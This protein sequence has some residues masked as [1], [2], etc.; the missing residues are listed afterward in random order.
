MR[1]ISSRSLL[2]VFIALAFCTDLAQAQPALNFKRIVNNW[3][4]IELYMNPTCNGKKIWFTDKRFF[5]IR[6]NGRDIGDFELWC[7]DPTVRCAVSIALALDAGA[8]MRGPALDS[9]RR[10]CKAFVALFDGVNDEAAITTFRDVPRLAVPMT[11]DTARMQRGIDSIRGEGP[12]A[13]WDGAYAALLDLLNEGVNPCRALLL[14]ST[15]RDSGSTQTPASVASLA[16]RNRIRIF[17]CGVGDSVDDSALRSVADLTDGQYRLNPDVDWAQKIYD[18][19][20][21]II[22]SGGDDCLI[23]Y[24]NQCMDGERHVVELSLNNTCD[25]NSHETQSYV[26]PVILSLPAVK[27]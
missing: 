8:R 7:P 24:Q 22:F 26:A 12:A 15:G 2:P 1:R 27:A 18:V 23:T 16:S 3:P 21:T 25:G 4:T 10:F 5:S 11:S 14:V 9:M 17:T 20:S 19:I 13:V 6:D